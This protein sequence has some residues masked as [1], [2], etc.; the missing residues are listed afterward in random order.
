MGVK[1]ASPPY[2]SH[3]LACFFSGGR[4]I[5]GVHEHVFVMHA[6]ATVHRAVEM[7][8]AGVPRDEVAARLSVPPATVRN[9]QRGRRP[10]NGELSLTGVPLCHGCSQQAHDFDLLPAGAYAQLLGLYLGDGC[11]ARV[12]STYQLRI[13]MDARYPSVIAETRAATQT[14]FPHRVV[15]VYPVRGARCVN[16]TVY[17]ASLPCLIPQH[18]SGKKHERA[19]HLVP[20]QVAVVAAEPGRFLR[21]LV[22]SDGWRGENRVRVKGRDYAY[23][24]YQFS[25]RSDDIR[26]LFADACDRLGIAWR[27]WGRWHV[28]VARRDAVARLDEHVGPKA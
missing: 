18:G 26:G 28:S 16:V 1:A 23:A 4:S 15:G 8:R 27:P 10:R 24:R 6:A 7:L 21:G 17:D 19:I 25:N 9:W 13:A 12:A 20:W 2:P 14:V 22:H 11:I 3:R 5:R